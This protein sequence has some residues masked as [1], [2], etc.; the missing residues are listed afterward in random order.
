LGKRDEND[1]DCKK[2]TDFMKIG[3]AKFCGS[4][5]FTTIVTSKAWLPVLFRS[6]KA[7]EQRKG[8]KGA[9]CKASCI[10]GQDYPSTSPSVEPGEPSGA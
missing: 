5:K 6:Y 10:T 7:D 9:V 8:D 4:D 1:D 2:G 3:K